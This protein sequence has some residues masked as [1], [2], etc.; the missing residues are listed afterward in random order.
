MEQASDEAALS[1]GAQRKE[2]AHT[3]LRFFAGVQAEPRRVFWQGVAMA[4]AGKAERRL[5]KILAWKG[6]SAMRIKKSV[7][8][9]L[10]ALGLPAVYV[11]AAAHP[12]PGE[13]GSQNSS[14]QPAQTSPAENPG[15]PAPQHRPRRR[16]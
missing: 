1:G 15:F 9:T 14:T 6:T 8:I 4:N 2:Y 16:R 13:Q 10:V 7:A 11:A 12:T 5:E 3:L